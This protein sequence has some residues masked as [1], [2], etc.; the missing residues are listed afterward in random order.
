[1]LLL[2]EEIVMSGK[3]VALVVAALVLSACNPA[4]SLRDPAADA[5]ISSTLEKLRQGHPQFDSALTPELRK[6]VTPQLL[7]KMRAELPTGDLGT[8]KIVATNIIRDPEGTHIGAVDEYHRGGGV[9]VV[10]SRVSRAADGQPWLVSGLHMQAVTAAEIAANRFTGPGKSATQYLF[11]ALTILSPLLMVAALVKVLHTSDLRRKWMWGVLA[12]AG[13]MSFKM[14][15][16]TGQVFT[17][18]IS[19]QLIG[20]GAFKGVG[21]LAPWVL[22]ATLPIGALLILTGVWANPKRSRQQK[23]ASTAAP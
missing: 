23:A 5:V 9:L 14:N 22:T 10:D 2:F 12:F 15:W 7:A 19:V 1:M 20:A 18:L 11:L 21:S 8:R 3:S 4:E 13:L 16:A 6:E 17:D